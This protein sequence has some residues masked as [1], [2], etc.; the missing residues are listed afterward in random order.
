MKQIT[1]FL[2]GL[3]AV[4]ACVGLAQGQAPSLPPGPGDADPV[5]NPEAAAE[6]VTPSF[7]PK[8]FDP[9]AYDAIFRRNPFMQEV[10]P[11]QE[12]AGPD[13]AW[14]EGL[15]LRA[16]TRIGGQF[17]VHVENTKLVGDDDREKRKMAYH[18]LTEGQTSGDLRI[19]TVKPHR[20][21]E[22]VEVVIATGAGTSVKTATIKYSDKQLKAKAQ[23]KPPTP[24]RP[25]TTRRTTP[26][27]NTPT[28]NRP[29]TTPGK[30][31]VILPPGLP[32]STQK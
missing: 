22:Q 10:V 25:Q 20:D 3:P 7:P 8:R 30:R 5:A 16:V 2:I 18:R 26:R 12:E 6:N 23:P 31:R 21:P 29:T 19:Q 11:V 32:G 28:T 15:I 14:A 9:R 13:D 4:L 27:P 17:V 24:G 1:W